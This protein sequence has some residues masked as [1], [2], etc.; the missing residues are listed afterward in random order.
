MTYSYGEQCTSATPTCPPHTTHTTRSL[1]IAAIPKSCCHCFYH[2]RLNYFWFLLL[3]H[4]P[5]PISFSRSLSREPPLP[6]SPSSTT[7]TSSKCFHLPEK[8]MPCTHPINFI[9]RFPRGKEQH[10]GS[11]LEGFKK[12][13]GTLTGDYC[14]DPPLLSSLANPP[15]LLSSLAPSLIPLLFCPALLCSTG[16]GQTEGGDDRVSLA[17][18]RWPWWCLL[19]VS[20]ALSSPPLRSSLSL[21]LLCSLK[22]RMR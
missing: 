20:S 12:K 7:S 10:R 22:P 1:S 14:C 17:H 8:L 21:S 15:T 11:T 2:V 6:Y 13:R 16:P 4:C 18:L 5:P 19:W 9:S 3:V